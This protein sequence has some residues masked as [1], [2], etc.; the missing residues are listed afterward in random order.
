ML[1]GERNEMKIVSL[2]CTKRPVLASIVGMLLIIAV[3]AALLPASISSASAY[4]PGS[5]IPGS[6]WTWNVTANAS[7]TI[8]NGTVQGFED[9]DSTYC[10]RTGITVEPDAYRSMMS[11]TYE[12][13]ITD[14]EAWINE[15][16]LL[17][18]K[19]VMHTLDYSVGNV[20]ANITLTHENFTATSWDMI[21]HEED[22]L[23]DYT[24][25]V[26]INEF[27]I[28]FDVEIN[29]TGVSVTVPAGTFT[30]DQI[31][32]TE[33]DTGL[34]Q[35]EWFSDEITTF[36]KRYDEFS[37]DQVEE[38]EL[39]DYNVMFEEV[40]GGVWIPVDKL[41]LLAPYVALVSIVIVAATMVGIFKNR[42]KH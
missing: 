22:Y 2:Q 26:K 21:W 18:A 29:Q 30:C 39:T 40:V 36:V 6:Y 20:D 34:Q 23:V 7:S 3:M 15:S 11:G 16:T 25:P 42:K 17:S 5:I 8:W 28:Y 9:I 38:W 27:D 10:S 13:N 37:Y 32:Y 19:Y 33:R 41:A 14:Y 35:I 1:K 12:F 4:E 24:P 31:V